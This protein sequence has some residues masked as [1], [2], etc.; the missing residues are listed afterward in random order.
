MAQA[1]R[2][3]RIAGS[4]HRR[5]MQCEE[6]AAQA[7][8]FADQQ[9]L[10]A[11]VLEELDRHALERTPVVGDLR[12][13]PAAVAD[14]VGERGAVAIETADAMCIVLHVRHA[15][16][17][18]VVIRN[19]FAQL[20]EGGG[21]RH[22]LFRIVPQAAQVQIELALDVHEQGAVAFALQHRAAVGRLQTEVILLPFG[23]GAVV[24]DAVFHPVFQAGQRQLVQQVRRLGEKFRQAGAGKGGVVTVDGAGGALHEIQRDIQIVLHLLLRMQAARDRRQRLQER[25]D[26]I[27]VGRLLHALDQRHHRRQRRLT[28]RLGSGRPLFE[29]RQHR[30]DAAPQLAD[31]ARGFEVG[32]DALARDHRQRFGHDIL[33]HRLDLREAG[34][35]LRPVG[36]HQRMLVFGFRGHV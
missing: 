10:D 11:A 31:D 34:V 8:I 27:A 29:E 25:R 16:A 17:E 24:A 21:I 13:G 30:L 20:V 23:M 7:G 1:G 33:E 19:R 32:V 6:Q 14:H 4:L 3:F 12:P 28:H 22:Q 35:D 9:R 2:G 18:L 5:G 26:G 36:A 15:H